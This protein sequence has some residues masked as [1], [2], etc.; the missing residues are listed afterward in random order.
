MSKKFI[1]ISG[2]ITLAALAAAVVAHFLLGQT[3]LIESALFDDD[4]EI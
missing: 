4:D 3:D 1:I 2:I